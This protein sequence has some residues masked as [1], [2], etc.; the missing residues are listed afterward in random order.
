MIFGK[1]KKEK[2]RQLVIDNL[3]LCRL[4]GDRLAIEAQIRDNQPKSAPSPEG[5]VLKRFFESVKNEIGNS[6]KRINV[7]ELSSRRD[8][9]EKAI[10]EFRATHNE[11]DL[12]LAS[13]PEKLREY[14]NEKLF[15]KDTDGQE[16]LAF[17]LMF[18][19]DERER[20]YQCPEESL[21]VVSE[22]LFDDYKLL[23]KLYKSFGRNYSGIRKRSL[24]DIEDGLALGAEICS[25]FIRSII[26]FDVGG[27]L[28]CVTRVRRKGAINASLTEFTPGEL[29]VTFAFRL[30]LIESA[31]D[32]ESVRKRT[33][34]ELLEKIDNVRADAEYRWYVE[35]IDIA[36]CREKIETCDLTLERLGK[37]LGV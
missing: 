22:I 28:S 19:I 23:G 37:I 30:T 10:S 36:E 26:S 12:V 35:G 20:T 9:A 14:I 6:I 11:R 17:A 25:G 13:N 32:D 31:T 18:A 27:V 24:A 8:K 29:S 4:E 21:S 33:V 16:R 5:S 2:I 3:T 15:K 1:R 7:Q 34:D